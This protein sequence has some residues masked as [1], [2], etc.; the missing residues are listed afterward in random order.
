VQSPKRQTG[1]QPDGRPAAG[2]LPVLFNPNL[3]LRDFLQERWKGVTPI[4]WGQQLKQERLDE[5]IYLSLLNVDHLPE[6]DL[7]SPLTEFY[8][9]DTTP[10]DKLEAPK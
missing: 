1:P 10:N 7:A 8:H 2:A 4:L 5:M 9:Y 3:L 6:A